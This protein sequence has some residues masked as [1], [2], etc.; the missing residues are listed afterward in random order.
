MPVDHG[1]VCPESHRG[2]TTSTMTGRPLNASGAPLRWPGD[3]RVALC[4]IVILE[5]LE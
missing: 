5:H 2:W 4:V 1:Y 3:A